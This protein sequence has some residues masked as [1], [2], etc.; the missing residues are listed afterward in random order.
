MPTGHGHR[1]SNDPLA[2]G[3]LLQASLL[4]LAVACGFAVDR[5]SAQDN[6]LDPPKKISTL[7]FEGEG[8]I[9]SL[10]RLEGSSDRVRGE[11]RL[12]EQVFPYTGAYSSES[13]FAGEFRAGDKRFSFTASRSEGKKWTFATGSSSYSIESVD[14]PS[15]PFLGSPDTPAEPENPL[16]SGDPLTGYWKGTGVDQNPDGTKVSHSVQLSFSRRDSGGYV[17]D[18]Y[19]ETTGTHESGQQVEIQIRAQLE[20][21][22]DDDQISMK[23]DDLSVHVVQ[24]GQQHSLGARTMTLELVGERLE[25]RIGDPQSG[26]TV[27]ELTKRSSRASAQARSPETEP[28]GAFTGTWKGTGQDEADDGTPLTFP[29]TID[30]VSSPQGALTAELRSTVD[31][32]VGPGQTIP[33]A[34]TGRFTG[35]TAGGAKVELSAREVL[36]TTQGQSESLGAQTLRLELSSDGRMTGTVGNPVEGWTPL[37][38]RREKVRAAPDRE[39]PGDDRSDRDRLDGGQKARRQSAMASPARMVFEKVTLHDPGVNGM[40]SHTLLKPKGWEVQGGPQWN[41]RAFRD[42]VH[43]NL[44]VRSGDGRELALYPGGFYEDSDVYEIGARMGA[45]GGRPKPGTVTTDGIVHMPLPESAS[46]YVTQIVLPANR[47][48]ARSVRVINRSPLPEVEQQMRTLMEPVLQNAQRNDA[49]LRQMGANVETTMSIVAER[50]RIAYEEAGRSFEEEVW[51]LGSVQRSAQQMP[52]MPMV[53]TVHWI[54]TDPRGVRAPAGQLDQ[55]RPIL[56]AISLS[57][58][59][60]PRYTA[61]LMHLRHKINQQQLD[62]LAKI[63][64]IDRRGQQEAW[65]IYQSGVKEQQASNDRLHES[66]N[67]YIRDVDDFQDVDGSSVKLPSLYSYVYSNG[68]GEYVLTNEPTFDPNDGASERWER[69]DPDR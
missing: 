69:I 52:N 31:Y 11:V 16:A 20:G 32:P 55:A 51:V 4:V 64:E 41:P 39:R 48:Q 6:P 43:I 34:V 65:E 23:T 36:A 61:V 19:L 1:R 68:Q 37:Q 7:Y 18:L 57:L 22:R 30:I 27:L 14:R 46:D 33:V 44:R 38:L 12:G 26:W 60:N 63:G 28:S 49:Q 50:I 5:T 15:R 8:L 25:G 54:M 21:R 3:G 29:V 40:A 24:T 2:R 42:F 53:N 66:F 45:T 67:D 17:A 13:S 59:P 35:R 62:A 58:Q 47:P 9:V 10:Q 56:E